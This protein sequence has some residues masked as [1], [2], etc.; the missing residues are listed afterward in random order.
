MHVNYNSLERSDKAEMIDEWSKCTCGDCDRVFL[1]KS[2]IIA[3]LKPFMERFKDLPIDIE[4]TSYKIDGLMSIVVRISQ[5]GDINE[6][7]L[8]RCLQK[9]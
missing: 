3:Q 5:T 8:E 9:G 2:T 6:T 1:Q 7:Q 4:F